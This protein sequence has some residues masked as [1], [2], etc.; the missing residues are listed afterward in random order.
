MRGASTVTSS[1]ELYETCPALVLR[2]PVLSA[3]WLLLALWDVVSCPALTPGR[4]A[5]HTARF[6]SNALVNTGST[7]CSLSLYHLRAAGP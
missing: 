4:G 7:R 3:R 5:R 2:C 1:V 6:S